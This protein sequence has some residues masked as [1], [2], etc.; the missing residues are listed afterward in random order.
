MNPIQTIQ[1]IFKAENLQK[2]SMVSLKPGQL[3]YGRVEKLLPNNTAMIQIGNLKLFA[4]LKA[5]LS[6]DGSYWFEV[7]SEGDAIQ[8][9]VVEGE[10]QNIS[11]QS[12]QSLLKNFQLPETKIN[13]QILQ[14]FLSKNLP[15]TKEHLR[16]AA[17]WINNKSD[18]SKELTAFEFMIKKDLPFTKQ[19]FQSLV[20]VQDSQSFTTQLEELRSY[21][22]EP[23]FTPLKKVQQLKLMISTILGN[24]SID[25]LKIQL[26]S[27]TEAKKLLQTM[28]QS[29]GLEYEKKV[30]LWSRDNQNS[31]ETLHSLKPLLMSAIHE[32]GTRGK[33][34]EPILNRLTGMQLISQDTTGPIHQMV[35]QLPISLG[36]KE[37]DVTLQWSGRK[38]SKGQIDPEHCRILFYLELQSINQTVVDMQIQNKVIHVSVIND[39]KE[40]EPIVTILTPT[41]KEKLESLG[42][43]LSFIKVIP[44]F[45]KVKMDVRQMNPVNFSN[46]F[47]QGVDIKI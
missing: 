22:E 8:L 45:E 13:L 21:L 12:S 35:M 43:K 44:S 4:H 42:Y 38:T 2:A 3:L 11:G 28:V 26:D 29:L 41:L 33:E 5:S 14:F 19:S 20:A 7:R 25:Q 32:L 16:A 9:K 47:Y 1:S 37:S 39:S 6:T 10:G 46:E 40:I 36:E 17:N 34:L 27:G 18:F 30:E 23:K 24:S 15:F 31:L